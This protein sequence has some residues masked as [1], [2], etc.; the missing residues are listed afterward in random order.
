M[1]KEIDKTEEAE[2]VAK[3]DL[4]KM[5][6]D[7]TLTQGGLRTNDKL[8]VGWVEVPKHIADDL[9]RRLDEQN[10]V[11]KRLQNPSQ[12]IRSKNHFNLEKLYLADPA[13]NSMKKNWTNEF[14]LMPPFEWQYLSDE[15]KAYL[16]SMRKALYDL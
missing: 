6:V 1:T 14:G 7:P 5:Y 11:A 10:E 13:Q 2:K 16:K 15:F 4:V 3:K 8:Y 12:P 9:Q